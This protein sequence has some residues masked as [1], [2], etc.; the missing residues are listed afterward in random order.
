MQTQALSVYFYY[1]IYEWKVE[2]VSVT[3]FFYLWKLDL[4]PCLHPMTAKPV[5]KTISLKYA[6]QML[7]N[8]WHNYNLNNQVN[9]WRYLLNNDTKRSSSKLEKRKY[10][11][12]IGINL[13]LSSKFWLTHNWNNFQHCLIL[14]LIPLHSR[15]FLARSRGK[16]EEVK[17]I[18]CSFCVI[19]KTWVVLH[20][21]TK[22]VLKVS[23]Y[24]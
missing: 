11:Y 1:F 20:T 21:P 15:Y 16:S 2:C 17:M 9:S 13:I 22:N 12:K 14:N 7:S 3:P 6:P 8:T 19:I 18:S 23:S 10:L 4:N 5:K 24:F